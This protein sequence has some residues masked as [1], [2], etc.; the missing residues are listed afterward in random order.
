MV[1]NRVYQP[2]AT[3]SSN[4]TVAVLHDLSSLREGEEEG[5]EAEQ[6]TG[7]R[8]PRRPID[9]EEETKLSSGILSGETTAEEDDLISNEVRVC[10]YATGKRAQGFRACDPTA[11]IALCCPVGSACLSD[12]GLCVVFTAGAFDESDHLDSTIIP[13]GTTILEAACTAHD[14]DQEVCGRKCCGSGSVHTPEDER[15]PAVTAGGELKRRA[16]LQAGSLTLQGMAKSGGGLTSLLI[17]STLTITIPRP[18]RT[19]W[20]TT[21]SSPASSSTTERGLT[22]I[23]TVVPT[24]VPTPPGASNTSSGGGN[25]LGARL[26]LGLGIPFLIILI[27]GFVYWIY[28]RQRRRHIKDRQYPPHD[29]NAPER[30]AV[31]V[32]D[33]GGRGR[34]PPPPRPPRS[35][36]VD[37]EIAAAADTRRAGGGQDIVLPTAGRAKVPDKNS[38]H[39]SQLP[40][41]RWSWRRQSANGEEEKKA[42]ETA[43]RGN[44]KRAKGNGRTRQA[45]AYQAPS[46]PP[47]VPVPML[48]PGAQSRSAS[49]RKAGRRGEEEEGPRPVSLSN[50]PL[51]GGAQTVGQEEERDR[52]V[53]RYFSPQHLYRQWEFRQQQQQQEQQQQQQEATEISPLSLSGSAPYDQPRGRISTVSAM[54]P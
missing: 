8:R 31:S 43:R 21:W 16:P 6:A 4:P 45:V 29:F 47:T 20:T 53:S 14:W 26:G 3:P 12:D 36:E 51:P 30:K 13:P 2:T 50:W 28:R 54:E 33:F 10:Y 34:P 38:S 11:D 42:N 41:A 46:G 52:R 32:A 17:D 22:G 7:Q 25:S 35:D 24:V 1:T 39:T 18:T 15:L 37:V 44:N 48:A 23:Q 40:R 9:E 49:P 27:M 19:S 5:E